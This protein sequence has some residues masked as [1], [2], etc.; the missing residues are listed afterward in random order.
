MLPRGFPT[1]MGGAVQC[2]VPPP[3]PMNSL[4]A[5]GSEPAVDNDI[6]RLPFPPAFGAP[7]LHRVLGLPSEHFE[8]IS[9]RAAYYQ[10]SDRRLAPDDARA[11]RMRQTTGGSQ[12][13]CFEYWRVTMPSRDSLPNSG[14][15]LQFSLAGTNCRRTLLPGA[16]ARAGHILLAPAATVLWDSEWL[17]ATR[18]WPVCAFQ[19]RALRLSTATPRN[20]MKAGKP[21]M[22]GPSALRGPSA[23]RDGGAYHPHLAS[24]IVSNRAAFPYLSQRFGAACGGAGRKDKAAG[25]VLAPKNRFYS[26]TPPGKNEQ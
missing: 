4:M 9:C 25:V 14:A 5:T 6:L 23:A 13:K 3:R 22:M 20:S 12:Q 11:W 17:R 15:V 7:D 2:L 21:A 18:C 8:A 1:P 24:S 19:K 10:S 16:S 26:S